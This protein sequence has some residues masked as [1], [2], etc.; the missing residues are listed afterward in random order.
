[1]VP[2]EN[3]VIKIPFVFFL[4]NINQSYYYTSINYLTHLLGPTYH[5]ISR[6]SGVNMKYEKKKNFSLPHLF[7]S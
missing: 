6:K 5:N 3:P 4:W 7:L 2:M 1:M